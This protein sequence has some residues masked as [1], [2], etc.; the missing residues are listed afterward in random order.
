MSDSA[1]FLLDWASVSDLEGELRCGDQRVH[2]CLMDVMDTKPSSPNDFVLLKSPG[3][4]EEFIAAARALQPSNIVELGIF[5]GGS[6]VA[7]NELLKPRKLVAVDLMPSTNPHFDAYL[8]RPEVAGHVSVHHEVN[9]A[10]HARLA[11]ICATAFHGEPIDIVVD[12]ASHFLNETRESFRALFPRLR[13]GG[14]YVIEDWAWAHWSGD[15][16]QKERGGDYFRGKE[17]MSSLIVELMVMAASRPSLVERVVIK[18]SSVFITKGPEQ[19]APGFD[20]AGTWLNRGEPLP[21][22]RA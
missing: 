22:F 5:R 9:Q 10:D 7:Y 21:R 1:P 17:P 19:V 4:V 12:D 16:W 14:M 11:E 15:Y 13:P 2:V 6:V 18:P 3:M 20:P 8:R